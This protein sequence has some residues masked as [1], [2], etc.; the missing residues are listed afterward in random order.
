M[1][2]MLVVMNSSCLFVHDTM[3]HID[4]L[5]LRKFSSGNDILHIFGCIHMDFK[6]EHI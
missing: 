6:H 4:L 3:K 1:K 2:N 5:V